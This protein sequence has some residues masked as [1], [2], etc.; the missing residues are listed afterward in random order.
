MLILA[1]I[2]MTKMIEVIK[3]FAHILYQKNIEVYNNYILHTGDCIKFIKTLIFRKIFFKIK[4]LL[5]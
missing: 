5:F 2:L 4:L 1:N 3:K